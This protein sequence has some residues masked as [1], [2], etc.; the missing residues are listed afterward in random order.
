[1]PRNLLSLADLT[2]AELNN[3]V[4]RAA[5]IAAGGRV[6]PVLRGRAVGIYFRKTS[7]RTR[8]SFTIAAGRLGAQVVA[9]GPHDLQTNTGES[10]AD[11]ARVLSGYLDVL[12]VRTAESV[13]EMQLL[14]S[15]GRMAVINAMSDTEHPTQ[16]IADLATLYE[17]F[18]RLDGIRVLYVGEGN[19]TA[20][21]LALALARVPG[22]R[23]TLLTPPGYG[24]PSEIARRAHSWA[25]IGGTRIEECHDPHGPIDQYDV[26]YATRWLTTGTV[27]S[28]PNWA[29][30]FRPFRVTREL[31]TRASGP[32]PAVFLHDLPAVRGEDVDADVLDGPYSLAFRQAEM[33][34][35]T[36]LAVLEWCQTVPPQQCD[37][38][39]GSNTET[40][41]ADRFRV[42][43]NHE[44]Q[45]SLCLA[46]L[47]NPAGWHDAGQSGSRAS[48]LEF[49]RQTW[50]DMRPRS[51]RGP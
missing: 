20:G 31:L 17:R 46:S 30:V 51:V 4:R 10:M 3:L 41:A 47:V 39:K 37:E 44:D 27:R 9:L 16:A 48:C 23:L 15:S 42:V 45:Y 1:M 18:G 35:Y 5:E 38:P 19:S 43:V 8:T 33:K 36:A 7:T 34:L 28:D 50:T 25:S 6:E 40:D 32:S 49:I 29:E 21:A 12:I 2:V 26:V 24:L 13:A 11:T 14:G 22:A